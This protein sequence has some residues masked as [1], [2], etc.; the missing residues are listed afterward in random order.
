MVKP[1]RSYSGHSG[2][3]TTPRIGVATIDYVLVALHRG[4]ALHANLITVSRTGGG[5]SGSAAS[6]SF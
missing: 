4:E 3:R 2:S 6:Q 5:A 1:R